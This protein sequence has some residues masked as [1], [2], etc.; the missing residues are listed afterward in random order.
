MGVLA[1]RSPH[2]PNPIGLSVAKV[3]N[4]HLSVI[5]SC[6]L[7]SVLYSLCR[8]RMD[9]KCHLKKFSVYIQILL[10]FWD[11]VDVPCHISILSFEIC[12]LLESNPN[13]HCYML[14]FYALCGRTYFVPKMST[15]GCYFRRFLF[16]QC[17][18]ATSIREVT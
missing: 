12:E 6:L 18:T 8:L 15:K 4:E 11:T 16:H 13:Y 2:R 14:L 5:Q 7:L 17:C 3:S 10:L 9:W 1:T